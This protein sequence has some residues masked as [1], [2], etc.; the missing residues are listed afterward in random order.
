[1]SDSRVHPSDDLQLLAEHLL[2]P[3][4]QRAVEEHLRTCPRCRAELQALRRAMEAAR[5]RRDDP[6]VPPGLASRVTAALDAEDRRS[7]RRPWR[8]LVPVAAAAAA[9]AVIVLWRGR[10]ADFV[11]LAERDFRNYQRGALAL[12]MRTASP[13][14]LER[15][16]AQQGPRPWPVWE[17]GGM[18]Y[19]LVGGQ[20]HHLAGRDA[21]LVAYR[22]DAG[23]D[24]LCV[25]Y[26]GAMYELPAPTETRR[27]GGKEFGVYRRGDVTLVFWQEG[28]IV[29][30][31]ISSGEP[32]AVVQLAIAKGLGPK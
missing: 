1:M 8:W 21:E 19:R 6:A 15:F 29:C 18:G 5:G 14:E 31:L 26:P 16:Y 17:L 10:D 30:V 12:E 13:G 24:L 27:Q 22:S 32:E 3:D 7:T 28:E 25:M 9:L 11:G 2:D 20:R 23:H 4:A